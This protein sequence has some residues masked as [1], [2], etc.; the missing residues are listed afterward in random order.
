MGKLKWRVVGW[1]VSG[2]LS[3]VGAL[4]GCNPVYHTTPAG[5]FCAKYQ[6][7][8]PVDTL[9]PYVFEMRL[10]GENSNAISAAAL[11]DNSQ[12]MLF[13]SYYSKNGAPADWS[14]VPEL[15][16]DS[17]I[18]GYVGDA[19]DVPFTFKA[20]AASHR[21]D[22]SVL[23]S[24]PTLRLNRLDLPDD[25]EP[26]EYRIVASLAQPGTG[27]AM[28]TCAFVH[29]LRSPYRGG[30]SVSINAP[31]YPSPF[32]PVSVLTF[33]V[34]DSCDVSCV[35]YN[36]TGQAVDSLVN[37]HMPPGLYR[38]RWDCSNLSSGVYFSRWT[39]CGAVTTKKLM[40]LK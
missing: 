7:D 28:T 8:W 35:V 29:P 12:S 27:S 38:V 23:F 30:D 32:S 22:D 15:R 9:G 1:Q 39:I 16:I 6:W 2:I 34:P 26:H 21:T 33:E 5:E 37:E 24:G 19:P 10:G 40:L 17:V 11:A 25:L 36:V 4:A 31:P 3:I 18:L 14:A 13:S 20:Y